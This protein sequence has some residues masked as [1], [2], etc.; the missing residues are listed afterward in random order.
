MPA[1]SKASMAEAAKVAA[2]EEE[3]LRKRAARQ[4]AAILDSPVAPT[5]AV[6]RVLPLG[7]GKI[8]MGQHAAGI[9]E[10]HFI[11]GESLTVEI[12]IANALEERGFVEI[13]DTIEPP[14]AD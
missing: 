3:A 5:M 9:G 12:S 7:D 1:I 6:C 13:T 8:S 10:V 2:A 4:A 11:K 14:K